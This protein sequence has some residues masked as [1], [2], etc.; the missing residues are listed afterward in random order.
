MRANKAQSPHLVGTQATWPVLL[1]SLPLP[2]LQQDRQPSLEPTPPP[3]P[4]KERG[5]MFL[6]EIHALF[7]YL[8]IYPATHLFIFNSNIVS[9]GRHQEGKKKKKVKLIRGAFQVGSQLPAASG[10]RL[11]SDLLPVSGY[12]GASVEGFLRSFSIPG[13]PPP[14]FTTSGEGCTLLQSH[15]NALQLETCM[16]CKVSI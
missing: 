1:F 15:N 5:P 9:L 10:G 4:G 2:D 12:P 3:A 8:S 16:F 14:S 6:E 11:R 7:I 13:Q